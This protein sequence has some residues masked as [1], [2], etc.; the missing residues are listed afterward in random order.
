[1]SKNTAGIITCGIYF[2]FTSKKNEYIMIPNSF[3]YTIFSVWEDI[4]DEKT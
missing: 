2:C 3:L 4:S 1:M